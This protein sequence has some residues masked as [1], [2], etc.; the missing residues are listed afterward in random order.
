MRWSTL[1][2]KRMARPTD[3]SAEDAETFAKIAETMICNQPD[4]L[5][6]LCVN[7]RDLCVG[8]VLQ[9]PPFGMGVVIDA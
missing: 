8:S 9:T 5:C 7:L 6:A 3:S 4:F 1:G 2:T